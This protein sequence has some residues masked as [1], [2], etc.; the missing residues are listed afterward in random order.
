MSKQKPP[1]DPTAELRA[2]VREAHE[3][4]KDLRSLIHE[5]RELVG[6]IEAAAEAT[7]DERIKSAVAVGLSNFQ[8]QLNTSVEEATQAV[9]ARFDKLADTLLGETKAEQRRGRSLPQL[10]Q[11]HVE[12]RSPD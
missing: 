2:A 11:A 8:T 3:V 6:Q 5:G 9:F 12:G 7:V 1:D 10:I 4:V